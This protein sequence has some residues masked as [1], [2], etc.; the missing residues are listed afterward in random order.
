MVGSGC[1][2]PIAVVL[3]V[4][5]GMF[6]FHERE[7]RMGD[8]PADLE[9]SGILYVNEERWGAPFLALPGDNE[10]GILMYSL[11]DL[12]ADRIAR[13]GVDFFN[14][15]ENSKRRVGMQQSFSEWHE[16]PMGTTLSQYLD[17]YGFGIEV[18]PTVHALV[19]DAISK[20]G[21][22]Y[23]YGRIG[24]VIVVPSAR[25]VIFAYAG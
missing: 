4:M 18:D 24:V 15:P 8:V 19:D 10:T 13:D 12:V 20:S 6:K 23:S 5:Y 21:S 17:Q 25:R 11:P 14:R 16:T 9:A 7:V 1:L 3:A 22:F 2:L